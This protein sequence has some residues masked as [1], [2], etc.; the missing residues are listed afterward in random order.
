MKKISYETLEELNYD[1]YLLKEAPERVLQFGEGN[2]LRAFV[3]YFIDK[4]NECAGFNSKVVLVQPNAATTKRADMI[5]AQDGLYTLYLRGFS[6]G[7]K[8]NDKRVISCVS[9]CIN[10][11]AQ[12]D[13]FLE[14]AANPHLRFIVSNTTEA[15]IVYDPACDFADAPA[16]AF[17]AKLTRFLYERFKRFGSEKGKRLHHSSV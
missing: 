14:C 11:R 15:G 4:M 2:F 1:G 5:N 10:A 6:E 17:P 3:D 12:H 8:V 13:E 9:R 7:S 16:T